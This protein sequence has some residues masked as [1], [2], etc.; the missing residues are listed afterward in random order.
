[1]SDDM[2][3]MVADNDQ[4]RSECLAWWKSAT[5]NAKLQVFERI[6]R[7]YLDDPAMEV[8]SR[9]AQLAFME[10]VEKHGV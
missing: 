3:R 10:M 4:D 6:R 7:N 1:M 5:P 8:M 2:L 9:F